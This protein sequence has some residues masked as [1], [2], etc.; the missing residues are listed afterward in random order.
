MDALIELIPQCKK[1]SDT[2]LGFIGIDQTL[3]SNE[4][5]LYSFKNNEI[6]R[7]D[8]SSDYHTSRF[9]AYTNQLLISATSQNIT[10][11]KLDQD[12]QIIRLYSMPIAGN[13]SL[14]SALSV[15]YSE[16]I[17]VWLSCLIEVTSP[18]QSKTKI[19]RVEIDKKD[20]TV[21]A[22]K[23][24]RLLH[25]EKVAYPFALNMNEFIFTKELFP[26]LENNISLYA[27]KNSTL[28]AIT[29]P[30]NVEQLRL[31]MSVPLVLIRD[32]SNWKDGWYTYQ[33]DAWQQHESI[34]VSKSSQ[35][36]DVIA[37]FS[38]IIKKRVYN[39]KDFV[40]SLQITLRVCKPIL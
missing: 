34:D 40:E 29:I 2:K 22:T 36:S 24:I 6:R 11:D 23:E 16:Q 33:N 9:L 32:C 10:V 12:T 30:C 38:T 7:I 27:Y 31:D 19:I 5:G 1:E 20:F 18:E 3:C 26:F 17:I 15:E 28:T 14:Q 21:V 37:Q 13:E 35:T 39:C 4:D 25:M 8:K